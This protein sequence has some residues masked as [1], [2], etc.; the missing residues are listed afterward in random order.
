MLSRA[1]ASSIEAKQRDS[2]AR[3]V[4]LHHAAAL[5]RFDADHTWPTRESVYEGYLGYGK[6][7]FVSP[8]ANSPG[9]LKRETG[10]SYMYLYTEARDFLYED[11]GSETP[12]F[13]DLDCNSTHAPQSNVEKVGLAVAASGEAIVLKKQG[14]PRRWTWWVSE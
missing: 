6:D 8:C 4:R 12:L 14:D 9:Y 7:Y 2:L 1:F 3:L 10:I 5:Y 13:V 11:A